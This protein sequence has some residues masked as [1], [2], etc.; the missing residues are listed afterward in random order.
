MP[1]ETSILTTVKKMLGLSADITAFDLDIIVHINTIL[2]TLNQIGVGPVNGFKIED[3]N[4]SWDNFFVDDLENSPT[5]QQSVKS[6][7]FIKVK[8]LFDPPAN[9]NI[10]TALK[11]NAKEIETRLYTFKGGY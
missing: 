2:S 3:A 5:M 1:L 10:L 9:A 11:E 6:Y 4:G 8:L 7:I